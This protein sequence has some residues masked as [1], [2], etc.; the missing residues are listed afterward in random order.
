MSRASIRRAQKASD[1][2]KLM[3]EASHNHHLWDVF[4]DFCEMAACS[5]SNAVDL[6]NRAEREARYMR[7]IGKYS[8]AEQA[9]FPE[10]LAALVDRMEAGPDDVLGKLFSE[11][12]LHNAA[13]GQFFTPYSV[14]QLMARMQIGDPAALRSM[15]ERRGFI[16]VS[17]P[18]CGAGAMMIAFAEAMLEAGVN[19]Q[20][21]MHATCQDIDSRGV[22]MCYLHLSLMHI[23]AVVVLGNTLA[24]ECR[25]AW[26][27]PAHIMGGWTY[28]LKRGPTPITACA[29]DNEPTEQEAIAQAMQLE[30][31]EDQPEILVTTEIVLLPPTEQLGLF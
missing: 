11:L 23:P 22:H 5:I 21:H 17:E 9:L 20:Q 2:G 31:P 1:L 7:I 24:V 8:K 10:M 6:R 13:R 30:Q 28:K 16:T 26:Y 15:I 4:A 25:E 18:A 27:T 12:E 3:K 14:C 19:P 29:N